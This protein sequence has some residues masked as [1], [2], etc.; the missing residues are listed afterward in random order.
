MPTSTV[1]RP[2]RVNTASARSTPVS[3]AA[4]CAFKSPRMFSGVRLLANIS[5]S[6]SPLRWPAATNFSIG[7][8]SPSAKWSWT[9]T[10]VLPGTEPPMS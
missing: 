4:I 10:A 8:R 7:T 2:Q 5:S 9:C 6:R 1:S 3:Q